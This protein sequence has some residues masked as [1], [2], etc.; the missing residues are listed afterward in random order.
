ELQ[1]A[2]TKWSGIIDQQRGELISKTKKEKTAA[3]I[4]DEEKITFLN[5][6][7]TESDIDFL[8][9]LFGI[10]IT[11]LPKNIANIISAVENKD[12]KSLQ[13][14]AHKLKGSSVTLGVDFV[15]ELCHDLET[16][17]REGKFDEVTKNMSNEL[18]QK[19]EIIIK[20][21]EFIREKYTKLQ[22]KFGSD[23]K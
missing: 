1:F 6:I 23:W 17:A 4:I 8:I 18:V 9:E 16:A 7:Q 13:F 22:S 2:L 19:L 15:S 21:L 3:K 5:D 14:S 12:S 11:E 10:Y 20:E